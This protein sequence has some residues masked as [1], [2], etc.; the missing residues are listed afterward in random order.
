[1]FPVFVITIACGAISGSTARLKRTAA[2]VEKRTG[3]ASWLWGVT[4]GW[5]PV[6]IPGAGRSQLDEKG[7]LPPARRFGRHNTPRGA[8]GSLQGRRSLMERI[9]KAL[10][11]PRGSSDGRACR[12]FA[13][14]RHRL[15]FAALRDSGT[16]GHTRRQGS[17]GKR[18][19]QFHSRCSEQTR[20][21]IFA[22]VIATAMAAIPPGCR[23]ELGQRRQGRADFWPL[24]GAP[25]NCSPAF[26]GDIL[27]SGRAGDLFSLTHGVHVDRPIWVTTNVL[28]PRLAGDR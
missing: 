12:P 24:F 13:G 27:I 15:P 8:A 3:C 14:T 10:G 17:K 20:A 23:M 18:L 26:L 6:I 1:M 4:E 7:S 5:P 9:F 2:K 21:T 22:V 25:I 19:R 28:R 16:G 11:H